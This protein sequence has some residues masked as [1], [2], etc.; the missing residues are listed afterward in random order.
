MAKITVPSTVRV[1]HDLR[2]G[3]KTLEHDGKLDGGKSVKG[4][5][6]WI[7]KGADLVFA[8]GPNVVN[9]Q[10]GSKTSISYIRAD[11]EDEGGIS[12][13]GMPYKTQL[14]EVNSEIL[15][16]Y[17]NGSRAYDVDLNR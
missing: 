4:T 14:F 1:I 9:L 8:S 3:K 17:N 7:E 6:D 16:K 10:L 12:R 15:R 5:L 2:S 11:L 13:D